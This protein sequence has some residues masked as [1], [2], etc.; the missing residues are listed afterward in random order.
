MSK[1]TTP[2]I[3][4]IDTEQSWAKFSEETLR[5]NGFETYAMSN[6]LATQEQLTSVFGDKEVLVLI[7]IQSLEQEEKGINELLRKITKPHISI[8]VLFDM[9]LTPGRARDAF[10]LGVVDCVS[11]PYDEDSLLVLVEQMLAERRIRVSSNG[12]DMNGSRKVLVIDD[13]DGWLDILTEYLPQVESVDTANSYEMA[14]KKITQK[15]FDL[16]ICDLR[17]IDIDTN[18]FQG[19]DLI[20]Q[21]RLKDKERGTFTQIIIVTAYG[22]P[23]HIYESYGCVSF[24]L[25]GYRQSLWG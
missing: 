6:S 11:K 22:T 7:D 8:V 21:I 25:G 13:D 12:L 3:L 16:V 1:T 20:R 19:M 14:F 15:S 23:E 24:E 18:N 2:V 10:R 9:E 17:L 5:K 4:I